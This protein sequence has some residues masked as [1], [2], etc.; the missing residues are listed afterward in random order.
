[1]RR[2]VRTL[3]PELPIDRIESLA[4]IRDEDLAQ[5]RFYSVVVGVFGALALGLAVAGLYAA[6]AFATTRRMF[7]FGV[8]SALGA[9]PSDNL[10]M[11]YRQGL[12]LAVGGIAIGLA[13]AVNLTSLLATMLYRTEPGDPLTLVVAALSTLVVTS[14]AILQPALRAAQVDPVTVLRAQ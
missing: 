4:S 1:V 6:V 10:W 3:D 11:V 2:I 8:R 9:R 7:E 12:V 5:P 14:A 13:I